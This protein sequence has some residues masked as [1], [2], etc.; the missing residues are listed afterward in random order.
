MPPSEFRFSHLAA[1]T[2]AGTFALLLLGIYTAAVGAGLACDARWPFCDGWMGLFP[3]NWPSFVEWFH[4]LVAMIVG[5]MILGTWLSTWHRGRSRRAVVA[6]TMAVGLLPV[7]I[8]LGAETVLSYESLYLIAHFST[9]LIIFTS[10]MLGVIWATNWHDSASL[11]IRQLLGGTLV[12][13]VPFLTLTPGFT[14]I[15]SPNIQLLYYGIGLA[16]F[17]GVVLTAVKTSGRDSRSVVTWL[18]AGAAVLLAIQLTAG[19]LVRTDLVTTLDWAAGFTLIIVL[20][21][22]L[23]VTLTRDLS[24][25]RRPSSLIN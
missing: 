1:A 7:Q 17:T 11:D 4:R 12:L 13:T 5:F 25:R 22:A 18:S 23:W 24:Q 15:H 3:A 19:R 14:V 16:M 8:W 2:V 20:S 6:L 10:L 9:A 21:V